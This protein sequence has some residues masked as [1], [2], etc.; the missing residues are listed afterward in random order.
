MTVKDRLDGRVLI[1]AVAVLASVALWYLFFIIPQALNAVGE[2]FTRRSVERN[3]AAR[4]VDLWVIVTIVAV[5]FLVLRLARDSAD[6][7]RA[8]ILWSAAFLVLVIL[9]GIGY[10][11]G[12]YSFIGAGLIVLVLAAFLWLHLRTYAPHAGPGAKE[13]PLHGSSR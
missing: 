9:N 13:L 2:L 3:A 10:G 6:L 11:F 8:G 4:A 12:P 1:A 5:I 7:L